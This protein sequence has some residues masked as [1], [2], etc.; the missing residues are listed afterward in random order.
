[1]AI[2]AAAVNEKQSAVANNK[3]KSLQS[4]ALESTQYRRPV[5]IILALVMLVISTAKNKVKSLQSLAFKPTK[6][7]RP[8]VIIVALVMLVISTVLI[9]VGVSQGNRNAGGN[10]EMYQDEDTIAT[11][12]SRPSSSPS[13]SPTIQQDLVMNN[14]LVGALGFDDRMSGILVAGSAQWK[15]KRWLVQDDPIG[16]DPSDDSVP[17]WRILQ[18]YA[19]VTL[20]F[21]LIGN[22]EFNL[23]WMSMDECE[24][25][26]INCD[27]DGF[28]RALEIGK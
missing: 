13:D 7:R 5:A 27:D 18:R 21:S 16:L 3:V 10:Q 6:Y 9:T 11:I 25:V 2:G 4:L 1:M 14:F 26:H 24:S 19:I 28:V 23:D 22:N 20:Q 17:E 15:A 8:V 12:T